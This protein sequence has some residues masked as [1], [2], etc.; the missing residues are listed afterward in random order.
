VFARLFDVRPGERWATTRAFVLVLLI[1]AGHTILETARDALFLSTL[2]ASRLNLVYIILAVTT[3]FAAAASTWVAAR[4]GRRR[5]LMASLVVSAGT[6]F[7]VR[8]L[9]PT[10]A[11]AI[12]FYVYSGLIGAVVLPQFW[13]L[14][15]QVFSVSQGRRLFGLL[16]SGGVFGGVTGAGIAALTIDVGGVSGLFTA[17][18]VLFAVAMFVAAS[19]SDRAVDAPRD[20]Q[21][22]EPMSTRVLREN[23]LLGRIAILVAIS[24]STVLVVDYLFK[25]TAARSMP[26][27][28]LGPFFARFYAVTNGVSLAVQ[29]LIASRVLR[30]VGVVGASAYTPGLLAVSGAGALV[31]GGFGAVAIVK[32]V[33][34]GLRYSLHKTAL[35]LL[36]LPLPREARE[37]GKAFIDGV[38]TRVAQAGTAVAL[39][40]LATRG[41]ATTRTLA[42]IVV[43]LSGCW[44][45]CV[46]LLRGT[47]LEL[48]RSAL[49]VGRLTAETSDFDLASAETLV[50]GLASRNPETVIAAM[51]LLA[52]KNHGRLIP[53]LVLHH[54]SPSVL[55]R[56][57]D[58][59]GATDRTDWIPLGERL[60]TSPNESVRV[61][62]IRA[63]A[64]H[65]VVGALEHATDD[66]STRLQ[67]YGAFRI[68]LREAKRDLV[69]EPLVAALFASDGDYAIA[70]R[71]EL[72]AAIADDPTPHA[73]SALLALAHDEDVMRT[74]DAPA[75]LA[76]A[77]SQMGDARFVPALIEGLTAY[78]GR[79]AAREALVRMGDVA[80]DALVA[81]LRDKASDRHVRLHVPRTIGAFGTQRACDVLLEQLRVETVGLVRYKVL[82]GLN[83][84]VGSN[85][86]FDRATLELE[87]RKNLVEHLRVVAVR[88][89]VSRRTSTA[90]DTTLELLVSLLGDKIDQALERAFR[91][92][93]LMYAEEDIHRVYVIARTGDRR[94]RT[95]ALEYLD[96]L[97]V[98]ASRQAM[99]DLLRIVLDDVSDEERARRAASVIGPVA[100]TV[101]D[102]AYALI[103]DD[104]DL[105]AMLAAR[106]ASRSVDGKL[107][108]AA[109][110][111]LERPSIAELREEWFGEGT[112][113]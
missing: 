47:Y 106:Y 46:F 104:D 100:L 85:V 82:R 26:A 7:A 93:K 67:V 21:W 61:S 111:A 102:A 77:M 36:Y 45:L 112:P 73:A 78:R 28:S 68:M 23:A 34:G 30:R 25:S 49:A 75:L 18:A 33:D 8:L 29:L 22:I 55:V 90:S 19:I 80:F 91:L 95:S 81:V 44:G 88:A 1:V 83:M 24:T 96:A 52:Q 107:G 56:A 39:Y 51:N 50:E 86:R 20:E 5:A 79:D 94:T 58:I 27:A 15:G 31:T 35:E 97:L 14:A 3:F 16:A 13:L 105:V 92:L 38:L 54:E 71:A 59:F 65:G 109:N 98:G 62:A 6:T 11:F 53:A 72:L 87:L 89:V 74:P 41:L 40:V 69:E 17:S 76:G 48:F 37:R 99:R 108:A 84:L 32:A 70:G 63:L 101:E 9:P 4:F 42:A 57:L 12:V 43:G 103:G 113:P 2:P 110:R 66:A 10:P 64:R 60:L